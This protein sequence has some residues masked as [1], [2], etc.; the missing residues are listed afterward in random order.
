M[1]QSKYKVQADYDIDCKEFLS[2]KSILL[3]LIFGILCTTTYVK[4]LSN[5]LLIFLTD[6]INFFLLS[7]GH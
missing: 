7:R 2:I 1:S 3:S 5:V 4:H 6:E